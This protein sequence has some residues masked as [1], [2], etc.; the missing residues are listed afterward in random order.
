MHLDR[1]R[2]TMEML[3]TFPTLTEDTKM[4]CALLD[5]I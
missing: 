5:L 2:V 4:M 1:K 3:R